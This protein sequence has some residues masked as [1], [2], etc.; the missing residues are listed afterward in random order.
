M[1]RKSIILVTM[2][3]LVGV[4]AALTL[5]AAIGVGAWDG[6]AATTAGIVGIEVGTVGIGFNFICIFIQIIV[7]KKKFKKMQLLQFPVSIL[8]GVII[9][10]M[11]YDIFSVF[12]LDDYFIRVIVLIVGDAV[13]AFSVGFVMVMNMVAFPLEGA[14]LVVSDKFDKKFHVI[15]QLVDVFCIIIILTLVF[16]FNQPLSVREGTIIGVLMFGPLM[17]ISMK[18][19]T[20]VIKRNDLM[21]IEKN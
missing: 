15:R 19:L 8:V 20:P 4:G 2:I 9:N 7:L 6:L 17:G 16:V 13:C 10:F 1:I 12:T 5:K 14:C 11:L 3:T 21:Y 18:L